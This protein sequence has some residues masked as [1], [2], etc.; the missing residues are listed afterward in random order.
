MSVSRFSQAETEF[1]SALSVVEE[2]STSAGVDFLR[3]RL[4]HAI[5][6][7]GREEEALDYLRGRATLPSTSTDLLFEFASL[8]GLWNEETPF[9]SGGGGDPSVRDEIEA[10]LH[11]VVADRT[12]PS[13]DQATYN[14]ANVLRGSDDEDK[15]REARELLQ[16]LHSRSAYY[17]QAWYVKL[18]L[19][20]DRWHEAQKF[21]QE[22]NEEAFREEMFLAARLYSQTIKSRPRIGVSR[23]RF[24]FRVRRFRKSAILYANAYDAHRACNH[25]IRAWYFRRKATRL[26]RR[27]LRLGTRWLKR[28]HFSAS[29]ANF[30]WAIIG[31]G[32]GFDVIALVGKSLSLEQQGKDSAGQEVFKEALAINP[33]GAELAL[34]HFVEKYFPEKIAAEGKRD[35]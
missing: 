8:L 24:S 31:T 6:W 11:R 1:R 16:A 25:K 19:A 15:I 28:K 29:Y 32:D 27:H 12:Y 21:K 30:D 18:A 33:R 23:G 34:L 14:L 5:Y 3:S 7:Q 4:A 17:S 20:G 2:D 9:V 13:H 26:R 10:V 35:I 22:G